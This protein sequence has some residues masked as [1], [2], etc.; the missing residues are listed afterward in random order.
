MN[1]HGPVYPSEVCKVHACQKSKLR[2]SLRS[3]QTIPSIPGL[4]LAII[5]H[6]ISHFRYWMLY[7]ICLVLRTQCDVWGVLGC[8]C[9]FSPLH[10]HMPRLQYPCMNQRMQLPQTCPLLVDGS[11]AKPA[12]PLAP[13]IACRVMTRRAL[14]AHPWLLPW[15]FGHPL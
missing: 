12:Y 3:M 10:L 11:S 13:R 6:V 9:H 7:M 8:F 2:A 1:P 15:R 14:C 5:P 4:S